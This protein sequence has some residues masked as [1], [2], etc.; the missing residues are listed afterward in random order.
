MLGNVFHGSYIRS[1]FKSSDVN[2]LAFPGSAAIG[3]EI[4]LAGPKEIY[5]KK[6]TMDHN[7]KCIP[8]DAYIC[9][10]CSFLYD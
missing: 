3:P 4:V 8:Y 9:K 7:N 5:P 2:G 1:T 6:Q 10:Y